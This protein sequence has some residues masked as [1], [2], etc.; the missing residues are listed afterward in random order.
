MSLSFIDPRGVPAAAPER[1]GARF[2]PTRYP[3]EVRIGLL[4]NG[5]PDSVAFLREV[6]RA[7]KGATERRGPVT[8]T[9]FAD[10]GNASVPASEHLVLG[11]A[12]EVQVVV[13]AYGH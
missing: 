6:E 5:F 3:G 9:V 10:K 11:M 2:D 1:Y 7:V 4:A 13:T 8:S 12:R